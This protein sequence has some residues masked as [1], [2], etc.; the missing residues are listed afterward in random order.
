MEG[1]REDAFLMATDLGLS[2]LMDVSPPT[3]LELL[4]ERIQEHVFPLR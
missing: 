3:G 1:L 4:V 2:A